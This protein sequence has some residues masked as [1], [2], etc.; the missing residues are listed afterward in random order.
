MREMISKK[1]ISLQNLPITNLSTTGKIF[2]TYIITH[3]NIIYNENVINS[4]IK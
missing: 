3:D 4:D 2:L 1:V